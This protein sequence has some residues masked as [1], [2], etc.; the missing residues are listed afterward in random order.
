MTA[1]SSQWL[2]LVLEQ[3]AKGFK[4]TLQYF[5]V[6]TEDL[7]FTGFELQLK[8]VLCSSSYSHPSIFYHFN[9]P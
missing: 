5:N 1:K 6:L 2:S 7:S 3:D 9:S 8:K 4:G